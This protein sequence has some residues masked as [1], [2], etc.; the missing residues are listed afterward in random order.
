[1]W[2]RVFGFVLDATVDGVDK[3]GGY[4]VNVYN[5]IDYAKILVGF[6]VFAYKFSVAFCSIKLG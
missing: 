6:K 5:F 3:F 2:N 4:V 1:M